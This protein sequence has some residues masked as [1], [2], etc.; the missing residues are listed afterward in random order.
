MYRLLVDSEVVDAVLDLDAFIT[1]NQF[2]DN[3]PAMVEEL[4]AMAPGQH[5]AGGGGAAPVWMVERLRTP[6][7]DE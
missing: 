3:D 2:E 5:V 6:E 7:P 4:R 1:D